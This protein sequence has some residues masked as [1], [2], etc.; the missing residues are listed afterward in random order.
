VYCDLGTRA[1]RPPRRRQR[2]VLEVVSRLDQLV[3]PVAA[4]AEDATGGLDRERRSQ[5]LGLRPSPVQECQK[6][7][8]VPLRGKVPSGSTSALALVM[9][10]SRT[11]PREACWKA[12]HAPSSASATS[13]ATIVIASVTRT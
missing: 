1:S 3:R 6:P 4:D 12:P 10:Q 5:C 13:P 11:L 8:V 7:A 9:S 2:C